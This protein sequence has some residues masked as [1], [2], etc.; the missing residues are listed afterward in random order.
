M[1]IAICSCSD[2]DDGS[3]RFRLADG[4]AVTWLF[5]DLVDLA[6]KYFSSNGASST[7][8][9][10]IKQWPSNKTIQSEE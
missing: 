3:T 4:D 9:N 10:Q 8:C 1:A 5:D 2:N 6:S 7:S